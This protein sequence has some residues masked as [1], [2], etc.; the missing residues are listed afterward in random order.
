MD[1]RLPPET[2]DPAGF[3]PGPLDDVLSTPLAVLDPELETPETEGAIAGSG[4]DVRP[5][6]PEVP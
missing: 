2:L 1:S 6:L 5:D 4:E 3:E